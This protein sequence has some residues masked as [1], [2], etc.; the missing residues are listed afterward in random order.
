MIAGNGWLRSR[1]DSG[2]H[3]TNIL[4]EKPTGL[5]YIVAG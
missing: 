5:E 4:V 1:L 3:N 2:F